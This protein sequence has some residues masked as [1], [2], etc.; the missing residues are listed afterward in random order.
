MYG[1]DGTDYD[2]EVARI[3]VKCEG[4]IATGQIPGVFE[5][6]TANSS[7]TLTTALT[8]DSSQDATFAGSRLTV[9]RLN[10]G[11]RTTLT[12]SSGVVTLVAGV[13]RYFIAA[14]TGASD[15]LDTIN[16]GTTGDIIYIGADA[17]DSITVS[18][19]GNVTANGTENP[20]ATSYFH[21]VIFDGTNWEY[22]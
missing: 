1:D 15:T 19:T 9:P 4:T 13:T 3:Q 5:F 7:G 17:E 10:L 14:E 22:N 18:G 16:G 2:T 11:A 6:S 8:I 21:I 12:I 20:L